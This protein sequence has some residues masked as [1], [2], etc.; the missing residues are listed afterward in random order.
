MRKKPKSSTATPAIPMPC[1]VQEDAEQRPVAVRLYGVSVPVES[2]EE[3]WENKALLVEGQPAGPGDLPG[4]FR[5]RTAAGHLQE[6][7]AP[8]MVPSLWIDLGGD[9]RVSALAVASCRCTRYPI[10]LLA[11]A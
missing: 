8:G 5:G 3:R 4:H 7:A 9:G 10:R 2:I 1:D 6:H 11:P